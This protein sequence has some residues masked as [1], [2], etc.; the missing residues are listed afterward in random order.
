MLVGGLGPGSFP[1]VTPGQTVHATVDRT[2]VRAEHPDEL[3][4]DILAAV[5]TASLGP[6]LVG[7][8]DRE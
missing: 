4:G 7:L 3:F 5:F 6:L 2:V 8:S 1:E